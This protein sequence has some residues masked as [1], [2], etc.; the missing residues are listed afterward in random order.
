[1]NQCPFFPLFMCAR[2]GTGEKIKTFFSFQVYLVGGS[3]PERDSSDKLYNTST[4]W[5]PA[6]DMIAMHRK[7]HLFDIHVPGKITFRESDALTAGADFTTF[8]TPFAKVGLGICYDI[9]FADL[10]QIYTRDMGCQL[11]LYPGA[12]NMTTGG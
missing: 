4:V 8:E 10:A 2:S 6:G 3:I 7:I 5:S 1:M 9:R 11:L 12:F